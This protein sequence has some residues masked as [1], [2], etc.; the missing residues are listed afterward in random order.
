MEHNPPT[1]AVP[2]FPF[3]EMFFKRQLSPLGNIK[4]EFLDQKM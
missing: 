4:I 2:L 3:C 1:Q